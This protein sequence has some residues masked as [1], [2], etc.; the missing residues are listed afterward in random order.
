MARSFSL[1]WNGDCYSWLSFKEKRKRLDLAAGVQLKAW[2]TWLSWTSFQA[3]RRIAMSALLLMAALTVGADQQNGTPAVNGRFQIV[4]AEERGRRNNS[5][6][7]RPAT[8][9]D[10]MLTYEAE[11]KEHKIKLD[12]GPHQ[13]LTVSEGGGEGHKG[14]YVASKDYVVI[15]LESGTLAG[16]AGTGQEAAATPAAGGAQGGSS[17]T[18]ILILRRQRRA[19][20]Q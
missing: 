7:Q 18:F 6:E 10:G 12:F 11:G 3:E 9:H 13:T 8:I 15:S 16:A 1:I 14:V 17:G 2:L 19:A 20:G 4:Y 5:W